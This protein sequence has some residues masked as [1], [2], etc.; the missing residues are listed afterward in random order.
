M[1]SSCSQHIVLV[2]WQGLAEHTH[3]SALEQAIRLHL[4]QRRLEQA[5]FLK[6]VIVLGATK[7]SAELGCLFTQKVEICRAFVFDVLNVFRAVFLPVVFF[8]PFFVF[9]VVA[10]VAVE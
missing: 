5:L 3:Q 1:V 8:A 6:L 7:L 2:Q 9:V 10:E 4:I